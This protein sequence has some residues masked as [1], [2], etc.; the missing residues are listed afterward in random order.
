M[1]ILEC[2]GDGEGRSQV[3]A[4]EC[5]RVLESVQGAFAWLVG[6]N[7]LQNINE[8]WYIIDDV[9]RELSRSPSLTPPTNEKWVQKNPYDGQ[10]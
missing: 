5:K 9:L 4:Q 10:E 6:T 1:N 3:L 7:M 2:E 8:R